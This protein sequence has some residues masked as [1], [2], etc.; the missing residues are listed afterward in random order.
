MHRQ[1]IPDPYSGLSAWK[2]H[3]QTSKGEEKLTERCRAWILY[4]RLFQERP[5]HGIPEPSF[6]QFNASRILL[7]KGKA[8][9]NQ[10]RQNFLVACWA[11]RLHPLLADSEKDSRADVRA[12][13][14]SVLEMSVKPSARESHFS[15]R[16]CF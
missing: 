6:T 8:P 9:G 7:G 1:S 5:P 14:C 4:R 2:S 16:S 15:S 11:P 10:L 12:R 3:Q 13:H